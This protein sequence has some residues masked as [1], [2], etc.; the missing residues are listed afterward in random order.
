[1][2]LL[3]WIDKW[4]SIQTMVNG[5]TFCAM[6]AAIDEMAKMQ[7]HFLHGFV[8]W[9]K[10]RPLWLHWVSGAWFIVIVPW[11]ERSELHVVLFGLWKFKCPLDFDFE[12]VKKR[13]FFIAI[14]R[15]RETDGHIETDFVANDKPIDDSQMKTTKP[16]QYIHKPHPSIH[17]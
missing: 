6:W 12:P 11:T 14:A 9:L 5:S 3:K 13:A 8:Q 15:N 16:N 2:E 4:F 1:M 7:S 10:R 17:F